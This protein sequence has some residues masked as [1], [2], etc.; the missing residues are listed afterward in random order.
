MTHDEALRA[1]AKLGEST[2]PEPATGS[3]WDQRDEDTW[4][5]R[6]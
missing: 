3:A 1:L 5:D 4:I 6:L 2:A